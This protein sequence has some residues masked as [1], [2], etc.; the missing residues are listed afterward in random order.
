MA[1]ERYENF[2]K[3][4]IKENKSKIKQPNSKGFKSRPFIL[5]LGQMSSDSAMAFCNF[6][7]SK[8]N[9]KGRTNCFFDE[10]TYPIFHCYNTAYINAW[11][12]AFLTLNEWDIP[13]LYKSHPWEM[14]YANGYINMLA[15]SERFNNIS[16]APET[17]LHELLSLAQ[18]AITINSGSGF[19]ALMH[20]KPVVTM[21]GCDYS[22][23]TREC[24]NI[25]DIENCKSFLQGKA[26][27]TKIKKFLWAYKEKDIPNILKI[28]KYCLN[29]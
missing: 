14:T 27:E 23:V 16:L 19:E 6:H 20:L 4:I 29:N 13:V 18:S 5:A 15:E 8:S 25:K 17:S 21:G 1:S 9:I 11:T 10:Y 26:N 28:I 22:A 24:K 3:K 12:S 7:V 2:Y